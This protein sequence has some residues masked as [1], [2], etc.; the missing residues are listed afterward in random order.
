MSARELI[1]NNFEA[2]HGRVT[3]RH[4]GEDWT[5]LR[6]ALEGGRHPGRTSP[7]GGLDPTPQAQADDNQHDAL[8]P[9][10]PQ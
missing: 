6:V 7:I 5:S 4:E 9:P 2:C 3:H 1:L 10:E 8:S